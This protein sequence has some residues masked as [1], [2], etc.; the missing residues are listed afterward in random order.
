M[1]RDSP[2]HEPL[3][4]RFRRRHHLVMIKSR[5]DQGSK[6]ATRSRV[7]RTTNPFDRIASIG[8]KNP[9]EQGIGGWDPRDLRNGRS[10]NFL[11]PHSHRKRI[12]G[13]ESKAVNET[14]PPVRA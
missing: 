9:D 6:G 5:H 11:Q 8:S 7:P 1:N 14:G 10:D 4:P 2:G 12:V 3:D 13:Q